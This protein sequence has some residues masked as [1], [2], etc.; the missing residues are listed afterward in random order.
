[1][2]TRYTLFTDYNPK[3]DLLTIEFFD[4]WRGK[5]QKSFAHLGGRNRSELE[6]EIAKRMRLPQEVIYGQLRN[7]E[8]AI[9]ESSSAWLSSMFF[10]SGMGNRF[11]E[12]D[13]SDKNV[14]GIGTKEPNF[15]LDLFNSHMN[16]FPF[17]NDSSGRRIKSIYDMAEVEPKP[18]YKNGF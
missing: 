13:K 10:N 6:L 5:T 3:T 2:S 12:K 14:D 1:M 8:I 18:K 9:P 17:P 15:Y 7:T 11:S 4:V 16:N